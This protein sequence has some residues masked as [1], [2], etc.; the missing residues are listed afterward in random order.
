MEPGRITCAPAA[1]T[2]TFSIQLTV[3]LQRLAFHFHALLPPLSHLLIPSSLL[4][5]F[6]LPTPQPLN[7]CSCHCPSFLCPLISALTPRPSHCL[8]PSSLSHHH[9]NLP[10]P[11][12]SSK[13]RLCTQDSPILH[14]TVA[15]SWP[16]GP[17]CTGGVPSAA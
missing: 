10:Y 11:P 8:H 2:P 5:A 4:L 15:G 12:T 1:T 9:L 16:S 17:A 7:L 14:Q 13:L 3:E 6:V